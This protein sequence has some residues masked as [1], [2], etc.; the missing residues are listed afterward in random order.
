MLMKKIFAI[1]AVAAGLASCGMHGNFT[2]EEKRH[3]TEGGATVMAVLENDVP[4]ELAY[5]RQK[6]LKISD[7][8]MR[9]EVF[10]LLCDKMIMTVKSPMSGGVGIAGPQV[11]IS[12]R[13]IAV[14]RFDKPSMPFEIYVNPEIVRYGADKA[15]GNEGCLSV[16]DKA[17][18][19]SRSQEIDVKYRTMDG[20]NVVETIRG[21]TAVI[22]QHEIDHLD[23][24]LYTDRA[25]AYGNERMETRM[26]DNG[27]KVTWIRDNAELRNMPI[28]LFPDADKDVV[29]NLGLQYGIPSTVSVFLLEKDGLRILFDA[30]NG[31]PDSLM[32]GTLESLGISYEDIDYVYMTHLHGDHIGGLMKDGAA[33][34]PRA[35]VYMSQAEYDAWTGD[36]KNSQQRRLVEAYEGRINLFTAGDVL[37]GD[38]MTIDAS[39]HSGPYRLPFRKFPCHRR[40]GSRRCT[41]A[42]IS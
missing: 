35:E 28:S 1:A 15:E 11:G 30:G 29:E 27:T 20:K 8:M 32:P 13:V 21:F 5:L 22:F 2:E 40:P 36:E 9:S 6:S 26:I 34:F 25:S 23:G 41:P 4:E 24:I 33:A 18:T 14:Q 16:P 3:I 38:V 7:K 39:G 31:T 42:F 12:R 19:V 17:G 37:P 10:S